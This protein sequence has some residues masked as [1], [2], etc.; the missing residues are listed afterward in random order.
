M[1][2]KPSCQ[3]SL[4]ANDAIHHQ[5][6]KTDGLRPDVLRLMGGVCHG[7]CPK[8]SSRT[9]EARSPDFSIKGKWPGA[10]GVFFFTVAAVYIVATGST[11]TAFYALASAGMALGAL[12]LWRVAESLGNYSFETNE[13]WRRA[14]AKTR[15]QALAATLFFYAMTQLER[16]FNAFLG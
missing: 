4:R 14:R 9:A 10:L 7:R 15:W 3:H 1:L 12:A 16:Y 2:T 6:C 8:K 13:L 5:F 11:D